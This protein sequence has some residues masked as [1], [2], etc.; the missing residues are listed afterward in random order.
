MVTT[1]FLFSGEGSLSFQIFLIFISLH[2]IDL[3]N[4][5]NYSNLIKND[6]TPV[7]SGRSDTSEDIR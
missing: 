1:Y 3:L 6:F 7:V 5:D 2:H 4:L